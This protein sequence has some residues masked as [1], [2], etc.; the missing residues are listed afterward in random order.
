M[1]SIHA[2]FEA[3]QTVERLRGLVDD[4]ITPDI[5]RKARAL[6][7]LQRA[8]MDIRASGLCREVVPILLL[9]DG[10]PAVSVYLDAELRI[11]VEHVEVEGEYEDEDVKEFADLLGVVTWWLE[12]QE[13]LEGI[14]VWEGKVPWAPREP[15]NSGEVAA[16][17]T[18]L[19][20]VREGEA[21]LRG[22]GS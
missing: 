16:V 3:A 13:E 18:I 5:G 1:T 12:Q 2:L 15:D 4:L 17:Q 6:Y 20:T 9:P 7:Y 22:P 14:T 21:L 8:R 10:T 19:D 11:Q